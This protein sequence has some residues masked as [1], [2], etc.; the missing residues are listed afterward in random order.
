[1]VCTINRHVGFLCARY[2]LL[3]HTIDA[4][5]R[6]CTLVSNYSLSISGSRVLILRECG[7]ESLLCENLGDTECLTIFLGKALK[8]LPSI[9]SKN[10]VKIR[11]RY[12][13]Y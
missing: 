8:L 4:R 11:P 3:F 6:V 9:V 12:Q 10:E 2:E 13:K 5:A 7:W 1:M